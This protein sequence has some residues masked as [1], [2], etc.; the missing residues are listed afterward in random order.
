[1]RRKLKQDGFVN[2]QWLLV[3]GLVIL[4]IFVVMLGTSTQSGGSGSSGGNDW[5]PF[6]LRAYVDLEVNMGVTDDGFPELQSANYETTWKRTNFNLGFLDPVVVTDGEVEIKLTASGGSVAR[7]T[8]PFEVE[9][10]LGGDLTIDPETDDVVLG[11]LD[12]EK[13]ETFTI[14]MTM[15]SE[16][17]FSGDWEEND[18]LTIEGTFT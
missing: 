9:F 10:I 13:G 6:T 5:N 14:V 2:M 8:I 18:T 15:S 7:A 11:P 1:M 12:V 3:I 16:N 4:I 17:P